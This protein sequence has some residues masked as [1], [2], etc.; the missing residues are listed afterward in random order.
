MLF[1]GNHLLLTN[2]PVPAAQ[3]LSVLRGICLI[4]LNIMAHDVRRTCHVETG[5]KLVLQAHTNRML[6]INPIGSVATP[7]VFQPVLDNYSWFT[8]LYTVSSLMGELWVTY[9]Y[10]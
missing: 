7:A 5:F 2:K 1:D 3:R 6:S 4:V 8:P 9:L 10:L